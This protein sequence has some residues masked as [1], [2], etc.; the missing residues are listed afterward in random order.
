MGLDEITDKALPRFDGTGVEICMLAEILR[1]SGTLIGIDIVKHRLAA[2]H[3]MLQ[4]T[5][6]DLLSLMVLHFSFTLKKMYEAI[7]QQLT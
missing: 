6:V 7:R 1:R 4:K 5:V 3:T 2:C